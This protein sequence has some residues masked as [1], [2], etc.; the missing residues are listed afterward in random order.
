[1]SSTRDWNAAAAADFV[2]HY[3]SLFGRV[4]THVVDTHL[5]SHIPSPPASVID[6]GGGAGHQ[7]LPLARDGYHVTILDP[8]T[9]MLGYAAERVVSEDLSQRVSLIEGRGEDASSL[10]EG[11]RFDVVCCHGVTMYLDDPS[12]VLRTLC[13]LAAPG[14]VVS[15]VEKNARTLAVRPALLGDWADA[16]AAFDAATQVNGLGIE[17]RGDT[18]ERL[19]AELAEYGVDTVAWYGVRCFSERFRRG[20]PATDPAELVLAVEL[21]ASRRDPYRAFSRLFHLVGVRR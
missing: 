8:S 3:E 18:P 11:E 7:S 9:E 5:R 1:M 14:G 12:P 15:I 2:G 20:E 19:G 21:E 6:V 16:L 13:S 17:T 10:L 4:R